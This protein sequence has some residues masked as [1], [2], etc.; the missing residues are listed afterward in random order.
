MSFWPR[1]N[2]MVNPDD[3]EAVAYCDRCGSPY[4]HSDLKWEYDWAGTKLDNKQLLVCDTC[5][6]EPNIFLKARRY[7]PDPLPIR[8]PRPFNQ[9]YA[10]AQS[11][12][13]LNQVGG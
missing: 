4:N 7:E 9:F 8:D 1:G 2:V 11:R 13:A 10:V 5:W 6:N 3:P 12:M